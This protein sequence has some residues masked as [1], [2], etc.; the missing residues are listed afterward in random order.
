MFSFDSLGK[1]LIL[2]GLILTT[3]GA[4]LLVLP[5]ISWI[6]KLPGDLIY[7]RG[8]FTLYFPWVTGLLISLFLTLLFS[9]FKK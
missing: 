3:A 1:V 4:V 5:K 8:N 9:L 2:L 7:Q 6:G